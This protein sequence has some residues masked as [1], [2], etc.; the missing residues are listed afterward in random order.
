MC[1]LFLPPS[2]L[3]FLSCLID[4]IHCSDKDI[5]L[6]RL[7]S[8]CEEAKLNIAVLST[9]PLPELYDDIVLKVLIWGAGLYP[10]VDI[11]K[12]HRF[13]AKSKRVRHILFQDE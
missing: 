5:N 11:L 1:I 9:F 8:G 13:L 3:N 12:E 6:F 2:R 10:F 4:N 7:D